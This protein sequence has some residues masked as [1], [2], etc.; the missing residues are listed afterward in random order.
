MA[1]PNRQ[2]W[3]SMFRSKHASQLWQS[4][5]DMSSSPPSLVSGSTAGRTFKSPFS[6]PEERNTDPKPRW[7]PRPEQIRILE[8]LFNSGMANPPRD[9]IPRIRMKLQEYGP[10]GDANVFYWFQNRKSRSKNKLLRAA[11]SGAASRAGAAPARACAPAARQHAAASPYTTPQP[12]QQQLQAPHVS[13]TMMAP[14]SSSS[15]SS[16]RSSGSSKP[17]KPT[18]AAMDLLSPLAAA[19]HQQMHYQPLGLGLQPAT[20]SAPA[21]TAALEEF[22]PTATD[23]EPIFLQYPQGHCLSAGELAAI[24]GAQY[25]HAPVQQPAPAPASPAGMLLG[26]CNELAAGP[27]RSGAWI[28]AGGLGQHWPSGADQLGLGKSSETFNA[29][30]VATDVAHEDATKLGLLHYGF[31]LS[32]PP[33]VNAATTSAPTAVLPLPASS[34]ETGAVTVASAAAAAAGLSNLF[35]T[36][37]AATSEAVTYSHLQEGEAEAADVG[38]AGTGVVPRGAAVVCIAGTNAVCNVPAGHLHVKTYFGEG[39]VLARFRSGRF[40]PLAVDASLGLT[41]EPLQHGDIYYCVLI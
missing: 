23:V 22:V 4:Q 8:A 20:V 25:M 38:F 37:T 31:G 11:G 19:C 5:P 39:A 6:G 12:K 18:T 17:V 32:S 13:P 30:A 24:L 10:V 35:A 1:S 34:P 36:T 27:T 28:G 26:L 14:T 9:E 41:V 16:D 40:E 33:A 29:S 21:A 3:P 2:T 15:S 7:N